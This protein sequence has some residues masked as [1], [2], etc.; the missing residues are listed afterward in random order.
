MTD[1]KNLFE[2]AVRK[3]LRG[4]PGCS[5]CRGE[6]EGERQGRRCSSGTRPL[7]R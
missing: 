5:G 7:S 2:Q 3:G 1:L 4:R 6:G